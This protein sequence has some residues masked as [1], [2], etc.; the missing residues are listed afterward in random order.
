MCAELMRRGKTDALESVF[1]VEVDADQ[2]FNGRAVGGDCSV[3]DGHGRRLLEEKSI[4]SVSLI[5]RAR[6]G[7]VRNRS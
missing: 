6:K 4:G 7:S 1:F 2:E 5:S 3:G